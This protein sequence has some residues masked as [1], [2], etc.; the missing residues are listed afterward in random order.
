MC[1]MPLLFLAWRETIAHMQYHP[2]VQ[3][4]LLFGRHNE[5]VCVIFVVDD[6]LQ[7]NACNEKT[8]VRF[9]SPDYRELVRLE[10]G[11]TESAESTRQESCLGA[12]PHFLHSAWKS[13]G[14]LSSVLPYNSLSSLGYPK[15]NDQ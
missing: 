4:A 7:I 5:V 2:F 10:L 13:R 9:Q 14:L 1:F 8:R 3:Q 6:V 15:N 12:D 11:L